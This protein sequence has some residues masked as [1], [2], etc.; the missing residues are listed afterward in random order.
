MEG[1]SKVKTIDEHLLIPVL[2]KGD[3]LY[4]YTSAVGF[5]GICNGEFWVLN[6]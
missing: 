4:H 6:F 3:K 1:I 5:Y 2:E